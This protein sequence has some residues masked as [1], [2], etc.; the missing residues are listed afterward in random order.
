MSRCRRCGKC[1]LDLAS[2]WTNSKHPLIEAIDKVL[3]VEFYA[4][5]GRPCDMLVIHE[6]GRATCLLQQWL[7]WKAK[8]PE[9]KEYQCE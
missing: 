5:G 1:C 2:I 4:D 3:P 8:P 9:C 6:N 7:G